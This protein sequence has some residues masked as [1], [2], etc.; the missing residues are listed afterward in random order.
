MRIQINDKNEIIGYV[1]EGDLE[2][3]IDVEIPN[4]LLEGF[5][6]R[7]LI[8]VNGKIEIN[9]NYSEDVNKSTQTAVTNTLGN[10]GEL[11]KMFANMQIQLVQANMIVMQLSKQNARLSQEMVVL[12]QKIDGG[13]E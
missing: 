5:Q 13:S 4:Y 6:P 1:T 2:G 11:R 7:K 12:N 3:G 8:Y 9:T 10:D